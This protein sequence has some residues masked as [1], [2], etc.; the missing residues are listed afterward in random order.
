M[1]Y[2]YN[3]TVVDYIV[4]NLITQIQVTGNVTFWEIQEM[5]TIGLQFQATTVL[6]DTPVVI[7]YTTVVTWG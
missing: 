1:E 2:D 7:N 5:L 4:C 3:N 6:I